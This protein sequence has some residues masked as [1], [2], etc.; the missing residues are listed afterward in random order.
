MTVEAIS[1][2]PLSLI[3]NINI[4]IKLVRLYQ[5]CVGG[6]LDLC[7]MDAQT[8]HGGSEEPM[9]ADVFL[10]WKGRACKASK[11]GGMRAAVFLLGVPSFT[12]FQRKDMNFVCI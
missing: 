11:H 4:L 10:D 7:D 8:R 2:S 3:N 5:A 9:R 1:S 6:P 12:C